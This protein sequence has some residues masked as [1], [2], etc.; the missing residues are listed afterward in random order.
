MSQAF[1]GEFKFWILLKILMLSK[2]PLV[3]M[4]RRNDSD[5]N[6]R[7][8]TKHLELESINIFP[9]EILPASAQ[10]RKYSLLYLLL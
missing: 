7:F 1:I 5:K 6:M 3:I 8:I 2:I 4:S 9:G 10:P